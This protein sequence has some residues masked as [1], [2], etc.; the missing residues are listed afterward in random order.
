MNGLLVFS[1][2]LT[3]YDFGPEHPM[4]P[5]RV[6]H[7]ISLADQL[8]VL[9]QLTVVPPPPVDLDLL[10][11]VHT[12]DYIAAV[13]RGDPNPR[14][15]LGTTDNPVFPGMHEIAAAVAM[16]STEAA[17]QVW[18]GA[19]TRAS[20]ISGG[21]HHAMPD[22]TS[23]FCVYNDVAIAI[24]WL[25]DHGCERVG[26][27]DVD[28]HHGDGVQ[29]IFYDDPRVMTISLHE[30]PVWLFPGTGFA[31]ETGGRAAVGTA[32]NLALP[33]G[34]NDSG[35]LRAFHAVVPAVLRAHRPS[36]LVTQHGCDSHR[37]DPLADL[38]LSLD[39]QRAS[40]LAL[41][42][43]ADELCDGRWVSTGGGGYAVTHVVPRAWTHL[44][45][46]VAGRPLDPATRIP[47]AWR[48]E[49]GEGAPT[50]MTDGVDVTFAAFEDGY[51]PESRLDQAILATRRAVFPA[52]GLD[53]EL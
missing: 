5:G 43:L 17:T 49:M 29:A 53:P 36:V 41:A 24:R 20:N 42:G 50:T 52:L 13:R 35:W 44:L 39:G 34:T 46:I 31:Y 8:G 51:T 2:E 1:D 37:H 48:A 3:R 38:D 33:P 16:A 26:Y 25:L 9:D 10:T 6:T 22:R 12:P 27:V 32:V 28:V 40:Y 21:L 45:S 30:T 47:E 19:A 18:K 7:S 15:G 4:S 11:T 23:G 14:Y